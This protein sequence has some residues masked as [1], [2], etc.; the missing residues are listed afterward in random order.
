M[1]TTRFSHS[2]LLCSSS[3]TTPHV[4]PTYSVRRL[5]AL[6]C[7]TQY[8]RPAPAGRTSMLA[9]GVYGST[10][11]SGHKTSQPTTLIC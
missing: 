7:C 3:A 4:S 1:F 2:S 11:V 8:A 9:S 5:H 10:I 6:F